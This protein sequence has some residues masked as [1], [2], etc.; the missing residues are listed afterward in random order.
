[1]LEI[2]ISDVDNFIETNKIIYPE[3][4]NILN[5][6]FWRMC[7]SKE[8]YYNERFK[9]YIIKS[10]GSNANIFV[11]LVIKYLYDINVK[12][13]VCIMIEEKDTGKRI[14][15]KVKK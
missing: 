11:S 3:L 10:D 4:E 8:N 6:L 12:K 2:D 15:S 7:K 1:M 5:A 13:V 14:I 9:V